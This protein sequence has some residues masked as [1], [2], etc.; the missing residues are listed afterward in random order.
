[1]RTFGEL[2]GALSGHGLLEETVALRCPNSIP[3]NKDT[4][5]PLKII[6]VYIL[7][8]CHIQRSIYFGVHSLY[9]HL[10]DSTPI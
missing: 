4:M 7:L 5:G 1:M 3:L 9:I 6:Q 10:P 2:P 8:Q